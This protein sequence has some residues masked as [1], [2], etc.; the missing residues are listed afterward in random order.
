MYFSAKLVLIEIF[1]LLFN[2]K[3]HPFLTAVI[4]VLL[5]IGA[6]FLFTVKSV[7]PG[8]VGISG[9]PVEFRQA[10]CKVDTCTQDG[11]DVTV[12]FAFEYASLKKGIK[13]PMPENIIGEA[14][15]NVAANMTAEDLISNR[16]RNAFREEVMKELEGREDIKVMTLVFSDIMLHQPPASLSRSALYTKDAVGVNFSYLTNLRRH[17]GQEI[18]RGEETVSL[19]KN[20]IEL[21]I[22]RAAAEYTYTDFRDNKFEVQEE[23][24]KKVLENIQREFG[25]DVVISTLN[26]SFVP[27]NF[28]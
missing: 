9:I 11:L 10:M 23:I 28:P 21:E 19:V 13:S 15:K 3:K 7:G 4:V 5:L 8:P 1:N 25:K 22:R 17:R 12:S 16:N 14:I 18:V 27:P 6:F 20:R 24:G 2:M 26:I